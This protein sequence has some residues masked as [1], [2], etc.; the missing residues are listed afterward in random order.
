MVSH[1][2]ETIKDYEKIPLIIKKYQKGELTPKL[3]DENNKS[4]I[5]LS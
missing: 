5:I 3:F 4:A 1:T 2:V